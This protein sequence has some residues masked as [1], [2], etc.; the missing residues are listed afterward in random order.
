M[1]NLSKLQKILVGG[2]IFLAILAVIFRVYVSLVNYNVIGSSLE[3]FNASNFM[4]I[5]VP[6]TITFNR[7]LTQEFVNQCQIVFNPSVDFTSQIQANNLILTPTTRF[8]LATDYQLT[9]TCRNQIIFDKNFTTTNNQ[10]LS[11][12]E[13]RKLQT[14]LD[15][16]YASGLQKVAEQFPWKPK[17][18]L[19]TKQYEVM[20]S[21]VNNVYYAATRQITKTTKKT[22]LEKEIY[23]QLAQI[24]AP[25]DIKI[26][27]QN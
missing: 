6:V 26:I 19:I 23:A 27:W 8:D 1:F 5:F 24:G 20:Y 11:D 7:N 14:Q 12:Q 21:D 3:Q 10:G 13:I 25:T 16:E 9:L 2:L 17:L 4:S 18:P 22:D 15:F